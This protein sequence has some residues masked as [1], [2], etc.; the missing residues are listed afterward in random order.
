MDVLNSLYISKSQ[1]LVL[2]YQYGG[3]D[4][5]FFSFDLLSFSLLWK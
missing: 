3:S 5:V 2:I 1:S 4:V